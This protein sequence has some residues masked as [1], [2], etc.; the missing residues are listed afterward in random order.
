MQN[1]FKFSASDLAYY[2]LREI[3]LSLSE[4]YEGMSEDEQHAFDLGEM[5]GRIQV[6]LDGPEDIE[7]VE[8]AEMRDKIR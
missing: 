4:M 5:W 3:K 7:K 6:A 2:A 1:E 8:E